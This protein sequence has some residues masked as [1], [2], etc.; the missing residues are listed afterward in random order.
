MER[1]LHKRMDMIPKRVFD[2]QRPGSRRGVAVPF[3][4][5]MLVVLLT[6]IAFAVDIGYIC[7]V[8]T[9]M[10]LAADAGALA[11]ANSLYD[12]PNSL[13]TTSYSIIM[14]LHGR[15]M[16]RSTSLLLTVTI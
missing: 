3:F 2:G 7:L 14:S 10:Q 9:E 13:E 11:G 5:I 16:K 6:F 15:V 1:S 12:I 4:A 8:R